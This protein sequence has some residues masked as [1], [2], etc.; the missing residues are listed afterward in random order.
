MEI[1]KFGG[2]KR[3][4]FCAQDRAFLPGR[5]QRVEW[6]PTCRENGADPGATLLGT[7]L[8]AD[9]VGGAGMV[10]SHVNPLAMN[11]LN[12][13]ANLGAAF[14][15]FASGVRGMGAA[16]RRAGTEVRRRVDRVGRSLS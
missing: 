8:N 14:G 6:R 15:G 11:P 7:V 2:G 10:F 9:P 13:L 4:V 16:V 12:G 1:E 5:P 3:H